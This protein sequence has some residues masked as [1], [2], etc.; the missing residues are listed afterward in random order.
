MITGLQGWK[1]W[2][3]RHRLCIAL[4]WWYGYILTTKGKKRKKNTNKPAQKVYIHEIFHW[5]CM[6]LKFEIQETNYA[7]WK[8]SW[9]T[10]RLLTKFHII[11]CRGLECL[12]MGKEQN[13][14][15]LTLSTMWVLII[16]TNFATTEPWH[17]EMHKFPQ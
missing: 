8:H 2:L 11:F 4:S 10:L 7:I 1:L 16:N 9:V 5:N 6:I 15:F 14:H 17:F 13:L 3:A 12:K